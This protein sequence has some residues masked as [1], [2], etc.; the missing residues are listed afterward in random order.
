MTVNW[1]WTPQHVQLEIWKIFWNPLNF[2]DTININDRRTAAKHIWKKIWIKTMVEKNAIS[3]HGM[4]VSVQVVP[5]PFLTT[6]LFPLFLTNFPVFADLCTTWVIN[7]RVSV[8][9]LVYMC[10]I[11]Q[12][13][14]GYDWNKSLNACFYINHVEPVIHINQFGSCQN[15]FILIQIINHP[16]YFHKTQDL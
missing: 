3:S 12:Q 14:H 11:Q 9:Q 13:Q 1:N 2:S 6:R 8:D 16:P 10:V 5:K 15:T 4:K 7:R